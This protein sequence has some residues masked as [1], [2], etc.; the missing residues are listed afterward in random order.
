MLNLFQGARIL[1]FPNIA[2]SFLLTDAFGINMIAAG[3]SGRHQIKI[4]GFQRLP[5]MLKEIA[6]IKLNLKK[7]V[8]GYLSFGNVL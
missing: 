7:W 6:R 3:L 2:R 5:G 1:Y 8:G 4:I